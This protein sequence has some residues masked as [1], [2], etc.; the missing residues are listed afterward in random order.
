M[1]QEGLK[2]H[3]VIRKVCY[4]VLA[5]QA[6]EMG[7]EVL[8]AICW[9]HSCLMDRCCSH[10]SWLSSLCF[11]YFEAEGLIPSGDICLF[12]LSE[13]S[14]FSFCFPWLVFWSLASQKNRPP[15]S[16]VIHWVWMAPPPPP[17]T[18][19]DRFFVL[20]F[21]SACRKKFRRPFLGLMLKNSLQKVPLRGQDRPGFP[22]SLLSFLPSFLPS[23]LPY[24][25]YGKRRK[26]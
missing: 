17:K 16:L 14:H 7:T 26:W 24:F 3:I 15:V 25:L 9:A 11:G 23:I 20:V 13:Q 5:T 22:F 4:L 1:S 10:W 8:F 19:T 18:A 2:S 6:V 21:I 12:L